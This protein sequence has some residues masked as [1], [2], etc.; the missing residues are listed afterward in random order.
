MSQSTIKATSRVQRVLG[1]RAYVRG[2]QKYGY[3]C[4]LCNRDRGLV[5]DHEGPLMVAKAPTLKA[6]E[7]KVKAGDLYPAGGHTLVDGHWVRWETP[8]LELLAQKN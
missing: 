2:T 3:V 4:W 6:L 8:V 1:H 5:A 7:A